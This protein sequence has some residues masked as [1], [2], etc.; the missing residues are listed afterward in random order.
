MVSN[1]SNNGTPVNQGMLVDA[2][3]TLSP[4]KAEIGNGFRTTGAGN[5]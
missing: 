1:R 5:A 3:T 4:S 2:S